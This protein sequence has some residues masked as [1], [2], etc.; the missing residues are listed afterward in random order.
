MIA[1]TVVRTVTTMIDVEFVSAA[2]R[3]AWDTESMET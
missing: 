2:G 3:K 1:A